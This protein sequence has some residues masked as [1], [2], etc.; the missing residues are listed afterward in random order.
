[1]RGGQPAKG[2]R[3][4]EVMQ[5]MG[6]QVGCRHLQGSSRGSMH[7]SVS[8]PPRFTALAS[9]RRPASSMAHATRCLRPRKSSP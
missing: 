9:S 6:V 2:F 3:F 5:A 1:M 8:T 4:F 7:R